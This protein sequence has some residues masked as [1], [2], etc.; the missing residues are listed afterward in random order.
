M[1]GMF[2]TS[3][4]IGAGLI[5]YAAM[6]VFRHDGDEELQENLSAN[7]FDK[8]TLA[9]A[10]YTWTLTDNDSLSG[11]VINL[12]DMAVIWREPESEK[13]SPP[14]P[15]PTFKNVEIDRFFAEMVEKRRTIKG[16]RR[17]VIVKLLKM[18]DEDG[19]CPSVV[20]KN[21]K[22]AE[23]KYPPDTFALLATVPLFHH[24]LQVARKC[25]AKVNQE[26]MLPD[27][28][29]VSL[30]H[31][32]GKIPAYHD[33]LY[34]TGDHPLISVIILNRITEYA[35]LPNHV[36]LDLIVRGHHNMKPDNLLTDLLKKSDQETRKEELAVLIGEVVDRDKNQAK[37]GAAAPEKTAPLKATEEPV[38]KSATKTHDEE[39]RDHPLG[40][41]ETEE[42]PLPVAQEVP[43]W[44][45]ADAIL[46]AIKKRINQ[47]EDSAGRP[48]WV[49]VSSNRGVVFVHPDGLWSALKEVREKNPTLL[50]ADGDE[51]TKRNLLY[52]VVWELHR[53]K[54]AIA[55]DYVSRKYYTTQT[56]IVPGGGKGFS[57]LLVPFKVEAFGET[58]AS[59]D[60]IKSSRLRKMVRDI[61]PKQEEVEKCVL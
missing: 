18:L 33:K 57:V 28:L 56:T 55:T 39:E 23:N 13:S 5:T 9:N 51:A 36:E 1:N 58:D 52:T 29:I 10:S 46:A 40:G 22:E 34:S 4:V 38:V 2:I 48:H 59:L 60:E 16:A 3:A 24:T 41:M 25:A 20:R 42:I 47:I 26:V 54:G 11:E 8:K 45:D 61:R 44:F 49:A 7:R 14:M 21:E 50:A 53:V 43:S 31:D 12:K 15:R 6:N 17:M 32:I 35:S 27:I 30:G 19:G 37:S